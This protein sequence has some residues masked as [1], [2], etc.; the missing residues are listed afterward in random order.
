MFDIIIKPADK[1]SAVVV[2]N[3]KDY[4]AEGMRQLSDTKFYKKT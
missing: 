1:G 3:K 2:L 4:I